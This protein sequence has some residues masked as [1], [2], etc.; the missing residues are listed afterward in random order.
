MKKLQ[1]NISEGHPERNAELAVED[2]EVDENGVVSR[3]RDAFVKLISMENAGLGNFPDKRHF[4]D[5]VLADGHIGV[6]DY[7]W[8]EVKTN[9]TGVPVRQRGMLYFEFNDEGLMKKVIGVYDEFSVE[10]QM[11]GEGKYSYP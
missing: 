10:V 7:V 11:S 5:R 6:V 3:G 9:G 4:Y 1:M 8:Q 2:V